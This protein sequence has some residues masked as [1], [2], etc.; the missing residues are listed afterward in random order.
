M[1]QWDGY[2]VDCLKI[3]NYLDDNN[4]D[5]VVIFIG[6]IYIFWVN[7]IY[8]NLG[9]ILGD[10]FDVLL[11]IEFVI[12]VVISSGFLE[13]VVELVGVVVLVVNL[14]ICYVEVKLCGFILMDVNYQCVQVEFYYVCD[15]EFFDLCGQIDES[16]I[17]LVVV[18]SGDSWLCEE[19]L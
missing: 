5:N 1:D 13:G 2:V 17:K 7:E 19:G 6:D 18:Y 3:F 4:I 15:I 9:F 11:V 10:L 12:L 14:Y 16:K 8:C